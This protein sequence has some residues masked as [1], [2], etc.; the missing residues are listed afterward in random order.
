MAPNRDVA[1]A[2]CIATPPSSHELSRTFRTVQCQLK[3]AR[4]VDKHMCTC[5]WYI[6]FYTHIITCIWYMCMYIYIY[7]H[8][9]RLCANKI[10]I[11]YIYISYT[12]TYVYSVHIHDTYIWYTCISME[13][14][15]GVERYRMTRFWPMQSHTASLATFALKLWI[16]WI[17]NGTIAFSNIRRLFNPFPN[18]HWMM[19]DTVYCNQHDLPYNMFDVP[20]I[21][22]KAVAEVSKIGNL[23]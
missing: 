5:I 3:G 9:K 11:W 10:D 12:G 7:I 17:C 14:Q 22:H 4:S 21:P 19:S 20:V 23:L 6:D 13:Q 8:N 16:Y 15:T 18:L 1:E 2:I